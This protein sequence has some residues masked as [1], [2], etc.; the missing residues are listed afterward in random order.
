VIKVIVVEDDDR[1]HPAT[2]FERAKNLKQLAAEIEFSRFL[3]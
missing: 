2:G 1:L 3:Y